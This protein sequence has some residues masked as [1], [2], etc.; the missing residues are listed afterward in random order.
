MW[1]GNP[2]RAAS[3]AVGLGLALLAGA[4]PGARAAERC[5][6][7]CLEGVAEKYLAAMLT[8]DPANAP[9]A[10]GARYTEG[11]RRAHTAGRSVAHRGFSQM[12]AAPYGMRPGW[13]TG[14]HLPSEAVRRDGFREY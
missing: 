8:H 11:G 13:T 9:L 10:H 12:E 7:A 1:S 14:V 2:M 4:P 5:E 3:A 6:R